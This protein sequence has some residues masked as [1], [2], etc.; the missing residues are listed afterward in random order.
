MLRKGKLIAL[1][2]V[3]AL[4]AGTMVAHNGVEAVEDYPD[5]NIEFLIPFGVGGGADAQGRTIASEAEDEFGVALLPQN[6]TGGGGAVMYEELYEREPDGYTLGW[7]STSI[8]TTTNMGTANMDYD[9]F[10]NLIRIQVTDMPLAVRSDD[11]RFDDLHDF[12]EYAQEN[13]VTVVNAG[14]GSATHLLTIA[15][16]SELDIEVINAPL[17]A[18]RRVPS[19]LGGESDAIVTPLPEVEEQIRA[20]DIKLLGFPSPDVPE[21]Y[22]EVPT[23]AEEG[24]DV[25]LQLFR[26][27]SAPPGTPEEVQEI[28]IENFEAAAQSEAYKE[29]ADEMGFRISVA[30]GEEFREYLE[31]QNEVVREAMLEEGIHRTQE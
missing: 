10:E 29:T 6:V 20:G 2:F 9:E 5:Q 27:I 26:G 25:E 30:S 3:V 1:V 24:Y 11:D 13:P 7:N 19:L 17:G 31:E 14:E 23:F 8:L 22:A 15:I 12:V 16:A 18:E 28:I 4:L 21:E